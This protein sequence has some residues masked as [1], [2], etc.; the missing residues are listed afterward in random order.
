MKY[1]SALDVYYTEIPE[2]YTNV[3][4]CR[5]KPESTTND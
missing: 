4:F 1:I 3:I 2:E 5:M